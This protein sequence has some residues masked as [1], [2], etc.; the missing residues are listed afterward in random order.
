M[1]ASIFDGT[2]FA[3]AY[4]EYHEMR[5]FF[6]SLKTAFETL[7]EDSLKIVSNVTEDG[8]GNRLTFNVFHQSYALE[9]C[10]NFMRTEIMGSLNCFRMNGATGYSSFPIDGICSSPII[11]PIYGPVKDKNA[12]ELALRVLSEILSKERF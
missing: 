7:S 3:R 2:S 9:V 6:F 12:L 5:E 10:S 4:D 11:L 1:A 8:V